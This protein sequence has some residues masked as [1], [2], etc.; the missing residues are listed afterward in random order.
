MKSKWI[1]PGTVAVV[2]LAGSA[3]VAFATV[4]SANQTPVTSEM[5]ASGN[6]MHD[7][8][9]MQAMHAQ[10]PAALQARCSAMHDQMGQMMSSSDMMSSSGI[11]R[12]SMAGGSMEGHHASTEG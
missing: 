7:S 3:G 12:G 10:M 1:V 4:S 5:L 11:V 6:S 2:L 8:P 9:A